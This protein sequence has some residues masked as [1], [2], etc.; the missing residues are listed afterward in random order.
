MK[1]E[2]DSENGTKKVSNFKRSTIL[3][4]PCDNER[5][6]CAPYKVTF[7]RGTYRIELWGA[8]AQGK[9]G[10]T[11]GEIFFKK[12][13]TFYIHI[14][15]SF[16]LYNSVPPYANTSG[17]SKGGGAT[18]IRSSPKVFYDFDSLKTRI[19][20]A[21][22][23]GTR[24]YYRGIGMNAGGLF[25]ED[26]YAV[27]A[28][29]LVFGANQT[30]GGQKN[31]WLYCKGTFGLAGYT[32]ATKDWGATGGGGY[33]GGMSVDQ[34]GASG[35]GS[36]FISGYEGCDAIHVNSTQDNVIHTHQPIHYSRF[37]FFNTLMRSGNES[38]PLPTK[39]YEQ[40]HTGHGVA[41]ITPLIILDECRTFVKKRS[42]LMF[43]VLILNLIYY[44]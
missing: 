21:A 20:V 27:E 17:G 26:G 15:A 37:V 25:G 34:A 16:G 7:S 9:G 12:E 22:G 11:K 13:E 40:G 5:D 2:F 36:S 3:N 8:S 39:G 42:N 43:S 30:S 41:R 33:Y 24:E 18:D 19:M 29:I 10:Y 1:I 6:Y 31:G 32:N 28:D 44:K 38:L 35:G 23:G 4:Y 14:G